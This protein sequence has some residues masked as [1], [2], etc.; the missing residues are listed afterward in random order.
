MDRA[1]S[2]PQQGTDSHT[3]EFAIG[4][5]DSGLDAHALRMQKLHPAADFRRPCEICKDRATTLGATIGWQTIY[6]TLGTFGGSLLGLAATAGLGHGWTVYNKM[7]FETYHGFCKPCYRKVWFAGLASDF[8]DKTRFLA[9]L[10]GLIS[11]AIAACSA[12]TLFNHPTRGEIL[13]ALIS[14]CAAVGLI[15]Y[16]LMGKRLAWRWTLPA[17][18]KQV[19][20][21]P[22]A[23]TSVR[24][25]A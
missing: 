4:N 9:A 19:G 17:S 14:A 11:L 8:A 2:A 10:L 25:S 16:A 6:H 22:F 21:L 3:V 12:V 13:A 7:E 15:G 18:L 5:S 23:I 24:K 1:D 20:P